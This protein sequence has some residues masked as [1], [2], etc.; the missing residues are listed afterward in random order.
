M[1]KEAL[2]LIAC[3]VA[4]G[5]AKSWACSY[6]RPTVNADVYNQYFAANLLVL[7]L[8]LAVLSTIGIALYFSDAIVAGIRRL[9]GGK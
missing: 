5:N 2:I 1:F 3:I 9:K 6:C 4:L 7:L 8:P